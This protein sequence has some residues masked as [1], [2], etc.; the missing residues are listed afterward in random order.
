MKKTEPHLYCTNKLDLA[1]RIVIPKQIRLQ[2]GLHTR[3]LVEF[4]SAPSAIGIKPYQASCIFCSAT[5][6][7]IQFENIY[8]Y[9]YLS[10][11]P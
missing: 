2:A 6:H 10:T 5:D 3:D 11:M 4:I 9:I 1:E 7:L 8:I